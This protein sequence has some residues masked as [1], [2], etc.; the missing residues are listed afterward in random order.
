MKKSTW[1]ERVQAGSLRKLIGK[2][3]GGERRIQTSRQWIKGAKIENPIRSVGLKL[4]ILIFCGILVCVISLGLFSFNKSKSIIEDKVSV[5]SMETAK[6]TAGRLDLLLGSYERKTMELLSDQDFISLLSAYLITTDDYERFDS[7]RSIDGKLNAILLSDSAITGIYLLPSDSNG[8][9]IGSVSSGG[10]PDISSNPPSFINEML[11]ANGKA[12]WVPTMKK[13]IA[14]HAKSPTIAVGRALLN[15]SSKGKPY[16][17]VIEINLKPLQEMLETVQFGKGSFTYIVTP[18]NKIVYSPSEEQLGTEYPH[19]LPGE[20]GSETSNQSGVRMLSVSAA[21]TSGGWQVVGNIPVSSLVD[22]TEAIS[23]LTWIMVIAS[24]VIAALIGVIVLFSIARPLGQLRTL[25]NEGERG[26]LTVRSSIRRKDEIGQLAESFNRMMEQITGLVLKTTESAAEVLSTASS[27]SEASRKTATSAKEIA[28]ATEEIAGGATNLA[29]ESERGTAITGE[30]GA[31]I[32]SVVSANAEMGT[33]AAEVQQAGHKGTEYM[34][35]LMSKTGQTEEMTRSMV[36]KVD[37]LKESTGSIRKVLDVLG[38]LTKQTNILSLNATIEAARAGAA[39]KGFMVVA[40][41]IRK[42]AD[43]SRQSIGL[44]GEVVA[45]IQREID[46]TVAVLSDAY[47][48][49]REQIESVRDANEIFRDV[50]NHMSGF[51]QR[52]ESATGTINQLGE[53][54]STLTLAMTNVSAVAQEA[55]ATSEQVASLSNE[56]L[57]ISEGLVELSN[58]L[59]SVSNEL[60]ESLSKFKVD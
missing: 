41:E 37:K 57:N 24:I 15:T 35:G 21:A 48:L 43:Q 28:V 42:L 4:F 51:V 7:E 26:N 34:G 44:V 8:K 47:P 40:D 11:E 17:L 14:D 13:G 52:L 3:E 38:N 49:F 22:G 59:E 19:T 56:Q 6:Q 10:I 36:E 53:A 60:R 45:S 29:A 55:S 58:R 27:L 31:K 39:G 23:T 20:S 16:L 30:I 33:A 32:E 46:E 5:S 9:P 2:S 25:M 1:R 50:Q 18:N 54:Q 12:V